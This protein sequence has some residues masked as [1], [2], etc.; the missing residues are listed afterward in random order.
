[1]GWRNFCA[2][3]IADDWMAEGRQLNPDLVLASGFERK[4]EQRFVHMLAKYAIVCDRRLATLI[5]TINH[6]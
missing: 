4:L 1:M 2:F 5:D 6:E 3:L